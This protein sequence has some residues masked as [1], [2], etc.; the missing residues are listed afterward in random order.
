MN[1]KNI[2]LDELEQLIKRKHMLSHP[3][4][5]A[6]T[7][8]QLSYRQLQDYAK[9]Y[10]HHVKAFPTYISALHSRCEDLKIRKCLLANL[11]DEEMG[12]PN[13]PEL[14]SD[15]GLALGVSQKEWDTHQPRNQTKCLI[16]TFKDS[17]S[18]STLGAGIAA[19]YCYESQIPPIC[20]TKIEGLKKWYGM[21]NPADYRYFSVHEIADVEHSANEKAL[22]KSL[23]ITK[24]DEEIVLKTAEKVL[25]ALGDFLSSFQN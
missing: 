20:K 3:F 21:T 14:W 12:E 11:V 17:C 16:D 4:Y 22:L 13:H 25:D 8:G 24:S 15:F 6:W 10:Y 7:C 18:S 19:L 23:V 5:Q 1:V 2:W 9:E